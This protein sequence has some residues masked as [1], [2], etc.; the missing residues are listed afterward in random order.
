MVSFTGIY[1]LPAL[2]WLGVLCSTGTPPLLPVSL[3]LPLSTSPTTS[4]AT[5]T[6]ALGSSPRSYCYSLSST[7]LSS[8]HSLSDTSSIE[9]VLWNRFTSRPSSV[10]TYLRSVLVNQN[11]EAANPFKAVAALPLPYPSTRTA[12]CVLHQGRPVYLLPS[13]PISD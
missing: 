5:S 10:S 6:S 3:S 9:S 8:T 1:Y 4:T 7:I 2:I 11:S 13:I 12:F